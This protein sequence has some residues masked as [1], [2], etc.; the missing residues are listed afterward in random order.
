MKSNFLIRLTN[1]EFWATGFV[2]APTVLYF[3][4]LALKMRSIFFFSAVNPNIE[5]GGL[6]G[7]SKYRQLCFLPDDLKPKTVLIPVK[8]TL[9]TV[10]TQLQQASINFPCIAKP[11]KAER[12]IGVAL[13]NTKKNLTEYLQQNKTD[14]VLQTY[15]D[16]PFEAAVFVY[17]LPNAALFTIPSI[18]T[19]E[20]LNVIGDGESTLK[21][22]IL[23]NFRAKLVWERLSQVWQEQ[24]DNVPAKGEKIFLEP[25]G[26]HNRGT[27]FVNGNHLISQE[28]ELVFTKICANLP[29]FHYGRLDLRAPNVADFLEGNHIKIVEVN[30]VNADPAHIYDPNT[31]PLMGW[32]TL[33]A[34]WGVIYKISKNNI[35]NGAKT[36]SFKEAFTHYKAW[37][38]ATK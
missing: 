24:L 29:D 5:T 20:F 6:F 4:W 37:K 26:N 28:L 25:I 7:A 34:H 33:L 12:G 2:H 36:M 19:K 23:Q 1:W 31:S 15:I 10:L 22:L 32:K 9:E 21:N 27:K 14:F 35:K 18:A 30:G 3:S 17:R 38:A 16:Y 13:L 11:D 8:S